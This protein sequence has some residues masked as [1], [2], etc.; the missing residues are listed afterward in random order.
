MWIQLM[1]R[2]RSKKYGNTGSPFEWSNQSYDDEMEVTNA[3]SRSDLVDEGA[4]KTHDEA[5]VHT[6]AWSRPSTKEL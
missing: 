6:E 5:L 2:I 1:Q 3:S 4:R